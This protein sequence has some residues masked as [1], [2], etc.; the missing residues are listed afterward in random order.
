AVLEYDVP[1]GCDGRGD[2]QDVL[3]PLL[4]TQRLDHPVDQV[5]RWLQ[6]LRLHRRA[7]LRRVIFRALVAA[8]RRIRRLNAGGMGLAAEDGFWIPIAHCY[9]SLPV[10]NKCLITP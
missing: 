2:D 7:R 4:R 1:T 5:L 10:E 3:H 9:A 6:L 8:R